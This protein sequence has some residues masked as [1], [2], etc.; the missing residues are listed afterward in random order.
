MLKS[1][2]DLYKESEESEEETKLESFSNK[3]IEKSLD[4]E[5]EIEDKLSSDDILT[6]TS[7]KSLS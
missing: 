1:N 4:N 3:G 6:Q 5:E 7:L 2:K